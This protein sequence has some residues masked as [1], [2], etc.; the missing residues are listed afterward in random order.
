MYDFRNTSRPSLL[1]P[2]AHAPGTIIS[3]LKI[4]RDATRF[5]SRGLDDTMKLWDVRSTK[6]PIHVWDSLHNL[7][8]KTQCAFSPNEKIVIT[9][10]SAVRGQSMGKLV[11]FN[12][13]TG[14]LISETDI[15]NSNVTT[16][17]WHPTLNQIFLGLSSSEILALYDPHSSAR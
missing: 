4:Y 15:S 14:E 2:L 11:A 7:S 13:M 9:G 5:V 3:N 16:V 12:T 8:E 1:I 10:T 17:A 6:T